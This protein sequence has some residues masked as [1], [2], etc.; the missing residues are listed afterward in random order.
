MKN[1]IVTINYFRSQD[2]L[3]VGVRLEIECATSSDRKNLKK[4]L[5]L[6]VFLS[7]VLSFFLFLFFLVSTQSKLP[8][9]TQLVFPAAINRQDG[10]SSSS[11]ESR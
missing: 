3:D 2:F 10:A 9:I 1:A 6:S 8:G 4:K 11:T 5:F 7:F